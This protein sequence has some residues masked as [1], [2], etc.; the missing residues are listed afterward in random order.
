MNKSRPLIM[1]F[2]KR[3]CFSASERAGDFRIAEFSEVSGFISVKMLASEVR[4]IIK[5][6]KGKEIINIYRWSV[7]IGY[8]D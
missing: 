8:S 2:S 7:T 1:I 4:I 6:T 3:S 5:K